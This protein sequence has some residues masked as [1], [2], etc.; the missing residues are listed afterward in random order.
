MTA[1]DPVARGRESFERQAWRLAY[2]QLSAA[3]AVQLEPD[4]VERLAITAH[5]LGREAESADLLGRA[6]R[7]HRD[8]GALEQAARCAFW[9][10]FALL[11]QGR[12]SPWQWLAGARRQAVG[13][14]G[15]LC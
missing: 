15:R 13:A 7:A 6:Y 4:D 11:L 8:R 14:A 9:L 1:P 2:D 12:N 3:D 5:L 10:A